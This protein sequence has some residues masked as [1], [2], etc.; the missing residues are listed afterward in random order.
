MKPPPDSSA[1]ASLNQ[2]TQGE[3]LGLDFDAESLTIRM[4][5]AP[6]Y[7][8]RAGTGQFHGGALAALIDHLGAVAG[9]IG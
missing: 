6:A 5:L 8:R 1:R 2:P 9:G 4:P 3:E 7:E